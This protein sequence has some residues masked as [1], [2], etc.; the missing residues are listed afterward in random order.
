MNE[1]ARDSLSSA[2]RKA[3]GSSL[4]EEASVAALQIASP[5]SSRR[6]Q[7][8]NSGHDR[9]QYYAHSVHTERSNAGDSATA[10]DDVELHE[11]GG[12]ADA[13]GRAGDNSDDVALAH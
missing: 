9:R 13:H 7:W 2:L 4:Y 8:E 3:R 6:Q 10:A 11:V 1:S 12:T 5:K